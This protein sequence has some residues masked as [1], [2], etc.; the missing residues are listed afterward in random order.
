MRRQDRIHPRRSVNSWVATGFVLAVLFV[1]SAG[2]S[3][4]T[5]MFKALLAEPLLSGSTQIFGGAVGALDAESKPLENGLM[6]LFGGI[7]SALIGGFWAA[8][9]G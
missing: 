8:D 4:D 2:A 9:E 6:T 1:G 7:F 5:E 3:C